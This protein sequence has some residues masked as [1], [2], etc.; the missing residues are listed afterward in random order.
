MASNRKL[1]FIV[2]AVN[3]MKNLEILRDIFDDFERFSIE[4]EWIKLVLSSR[5]HFLEQFNFT[6][7]KARIPFPSTKFYKP[8]EF[9]DFVRLSRIEDDE[10]KEFYNIYRKHYSFFPKDH[11]ELSENIQNRLREPLVLWLVSEICAGKN[12]NDFESTPKYLCEDL[13]L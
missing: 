10:F 13:A 1:V 7:E 6:L 5:P 3:E 4:T 12:I 2:D 8:S 9:D 11:K